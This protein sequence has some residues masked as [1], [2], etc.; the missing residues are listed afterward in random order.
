MPSLAACRCLFRLMR[1][2]L[3]VRW[4]CLPV[5]ER[6]RLVWKFLLDLICLY[7]SDYFF[8]I[9]EAHVGCTE[10]CSERHMASRQQFAHSCST[11]M[12]SSS[13]QAACPDLPDPISP[14]ICIVH[15]S[16]AV[17]Q[18]NFCIGTE[19]LNIGSSW[20]SNLSRPCERRTQALNNPRKQICHDA[21]KPNKTRL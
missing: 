1:R 12:S 16:R 7:A 10:Q 15:R 4:I 20:L 18:A 9:L 17:F 21:T 14:P 8:Y 2:F 5:S 13:C 11:R 6:F 3:L 19:L